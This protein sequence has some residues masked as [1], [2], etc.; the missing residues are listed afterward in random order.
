MTVLRDPLGHLLKGDALPGVNDNRTAGHR[1]TGVFIRDRT[2]IDP[3]TW[4]FL[5]NRC[6]VSQLS[7]HFPGPL[8][9]SNGVFSDVLCLSETGTALQQS[10]CNH[11]SKKFFVHR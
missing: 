11:N 4:G 6:P 1:I 9:F 8:L 3:L 2:G 7:D 5:Y 10:G